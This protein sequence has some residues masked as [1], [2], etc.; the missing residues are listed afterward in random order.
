MS[1]KCLLRP[2]PC[3]HAFQP[4]V[5]MRSP[6]HTACHAWYIPFRKARDVRAPSVHLRNGS[7][8]AERPAHGLHW[9]ML[10]AQQQQSALQGSAVS[11]SVFKT[12]PSLPVL[13]KTEMLSSHRLP[14]DAYVVQG[15]VL[16]AAALLALAAASYAG[17]AGA[18]VAGT[19]AAVSSTA[20]DEVS[21]AFIPGALL[22]LPYVIGTGACTLLITDSLN[23]PSLCC[24]NLWACQGQVL[25]EG[26]VDTS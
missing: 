22:S 11:A 5:R 9:R 26:K 16:A 25:T 8:S 12:S 24:E 14:E 21:S 3:T 19:G 23:E 6:T 18:A 20:I 15:H 7:C 17:A 4:H 10:A 13:L 1:S 2:C